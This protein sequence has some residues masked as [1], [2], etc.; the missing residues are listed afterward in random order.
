MDIK[1]KPC[2]F[3][4]EKAV[5]AVDVGVRVMCSKC[6]I[7]TEKLYACQNDTVGIYHAAL[8]ATDAWNRRADDET[9]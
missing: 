5:I 9:N 4:G 6:G 1:L 3:C 8:A 7:Q 2:P